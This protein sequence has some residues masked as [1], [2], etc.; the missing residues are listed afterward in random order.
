MVEPHLK[1]FSDRSELVAENGSSTIYHEGP[2]AQGTTARTKQIRKKFENKWFLKFVKDTISSPDI[3][4]PLDST[5]RELLEKLINSVTSETGRCLVGLSIVQMAIKSLEPSQSIRLHKGGRGAFSWKDGIT[6]RTL[7]SDFITPVL[8]EFDLLKVNKYGNM[9]TRSLAENYPYSQFYKAAIKGGKQLWLDLV[10]EI[11]F[12]RLNAEV[13][14]KYSIILLYKKSEIFNH[15]VNET[16]TA[17]DN[18]LLKNPTMDDIF[19]LIDTHINK[20]TYSPRLLEIACHSLFQVA[21]ENKAIEGYLVPLSQMRSANKKHNNVA[22]VEIESVKGSGRIIEAWDAKYGKP[23]LIDELQE[24]KDKL[25]SNSD[26]EIAGFVTECE[27]MINDEIISSINDIS[28]FTD[29]IIE[30]KSFKDWVF[31]IVTKME[32]DVSK[33]GKAWLRA[34]TETICLKRLNKAPIDEPADVWIM[35]LGRLIRK[36]Q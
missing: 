12:G 7:D 32:L 31:D 28:E 13:A 29:T 23:Y 35:S 11:E 17:L 21:E 30:I 4:I 26:V 27:P 25:L 33:V 20:S 6:M 3:D 1:V 2:P 15:H 19:I 14:L 9:M 36:A 18:Y 24:L 22:D 8:R 10:D 34:Y 16:I 5:H